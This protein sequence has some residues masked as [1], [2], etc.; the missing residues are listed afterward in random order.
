MLGRNLTPKRSTPSSRMRPRPPTQGEKNIEA[1][2][3]HLCELYHQPPA[4]PELSNWYT[5]GCSHPYIAA[6]VQDLYTDYSQTSQHH[7]VF[8]VAK[9]RLLLT[10]TGHPLEE[11]Y[12]RVLKLY[13]ERLTYIHCAGIARVTLWVE[14][15]EDCVKSDALRNEAFIAACESTLSFHEQDYVHRKLEFITEVYALLETCDAGNASRVVRDLE[16]M[17]PWTKG[18]FIMRLTQCVVGYDRVK[19]ADLDVVREEEEM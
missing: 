15:H 1:A 6:R 17:W 11:I 9:L 18:D 2:R 4:I 13:D 8:Y 5:L 16:A 10:P 7:G 12:T 19:L 3:R 14:W